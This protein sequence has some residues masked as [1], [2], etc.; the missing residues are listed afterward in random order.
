MWG[1]EGEG[2]DWIIILLLLGKG[3]D[4]MVAAGGRLRQ[5]DDEEG[6][7]C[8]VLILELLV[9]MG[10]KRWEIAKVGWLLTKKKQYQHTSS[11]VNEGYLI[12]NY[13]V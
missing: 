12:L 9:L 11:W 6:W 13:H 3:D 2:F 10:N 7:T 5:D 1:H 4:R 8:D